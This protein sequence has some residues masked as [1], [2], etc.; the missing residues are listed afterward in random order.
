MLIK[1]ISFSCIFAIITMAQLSAYFEPSQLET[2]VNFPN[3]VETYF[4]TKNNGNW[5]SSTTWEVSSDQINW[6]AS[7]SYP[8]ENATAVE[9][10]APHEVTLDQHNLF[11]QNTSVYGTLVVED[12]DFVVPE[13]VN[14][15]ALQVKPSGK[16]L[17]NGQGVNNG[18]GKALVETNGKVEL[19]KFETVSILAEKFISTH[20]NSLFVF[21]DLAIV[22]WNYNDNE[23]LGSVGFS[24]FFKMSEPHTFVV[25]QLNQDFPKNGESFGGGTNHVFNAVLEVEGSRYLRLQGNGN[26][27]FVGGIQGTGTLKVNYL[28]GHGKLI[29]GN[30]HI[31]PTL[32]NQGLL[33]IEV[34]HNLL[35]F[36]NGGMVPN[37]AEVVL[38][39]LNEN[40]EI[41]RKNGVFTIDGTLDLG[42]FRWTNSETLG[43][44]AVNGILRTAH[45][46]GLHGGSSAIPSGNLTLND[47]SRIV[48]NGADQIISNLD[49]YHLVCAGSGVKT[50]QNATKIHS[51]GSVHIS[52]DAVVDFTLHNLASTGANNTA[53]SMDGGRLIL[54]RGGTQPNMRGNYDLSAG[55]VEF[56][57]RNQSIRSSQ[58][59]KYQNIEV[60]GEGVRNSSGH[61]RLRSNGTFV[62]KENSVFTIKKNSIRC[63]DGTSSGES[64]EENCQVVVSSNAVFQTG[65]SQGFS[66]F[67]PTFSDDAAIAFEISDIQ[68]MNGSTVEYLGEKAQVIS[69]QTN[70]G[71]GS[72]GNYYNLKISG[73]EILPFEGILTVNHLTQISPEG[74][75]VL[76]EVDEYSPNIHALYALKGIQVEEGGSLLLKNNAVLMQDEDAINSGAIQSEKTFHFSTERKQYNFVHSPLVGQ[77]LKEIYPNSSHVLRYN[78]ATDF[79][80]TTDGSYLPGRGLAM[81]EASGNG[82]EEVSAVFEGLPM[83]G[84]FSYPLEKAGQGFNLVGNPYPS[85]LDIRQLY[86]DNS[87]WIHNDFYFWDNRTNEIY[88]QQG[89]AYS[90]VNYA[91][92][93]ATAGTNGTGLG[94]ACTQ[95]DASKIPTKNVKIG[96]AFILQAKSAGALNFKN[97]YRTVQNDGPNFL[98]KKTD[99]FEAVED[100]RFWLTMTTPKGVTVM[101]AIVYFDDGKDAFSNDDTEAFQV[102]DELYSWVSEHQMI[103]QGK[104]AF[105]VKDKV[106]LGF[107]AFEEGIYAIKLFQQ[108]GIFNQ[109]Q[110]IYLMDEYLG[111]IH[112]LS[113]S[114]YVFKTESGEFNDRFVLV[115]ELDESLS[116]L[117]AA[118]EKLQIYQQNESL[119]IRSLKEDLRAVKAFD[120]SGQLLFENDSLT[121]KNYVL[122]KGKLAK[123]SLFLLLTTADET[124]HSF[125]IYHP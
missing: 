60:S 38:T 106:A 82:T 96:T 80:V 15:Y 98:G 65:N 9:I 8:D 72:E 20:A 33:S 44:I 77:N 63:Y 62:L 110:S 120:L 74:R 7:F 111:E 6:T 118:T 104:S 36:S 51:E 107:R 11:L 54:G 109:G 19:K 30:E 48:Y 102:S 27:T 108:E 17:L 75:L 99:D 70:V 29:I 16:F 14:A 121:G 73:D 92:F 78:E 100:D 13:K 43:G 59:Q 94:A 97:S 39:S 117:N 124:I 64:I 88:E 89:A 67:T 49:Y 25:F 105:V 52:E 122:P 21:E 28:S 90:G 10:L 55:V 123:K 116:S 18:N 4:R 115:Y 41:T 84:N 85:S 58:S 40:P 76:A 26:K 101:N 125:K 56:V 3:E 87:T 79:F 23:I 47:D 32:G 53:F 93:N 35:Q 83:N 66:G 103:I 119:H 34:P 2:V 86:L 113:E 46:G 57:G 114:P 112:H 1:L 68:L 42:K 71:Q 91:T 81:K 5:T 50:P 45:S 22:N 12:N 24:E 69:T 95:C 61:I 37:A 31:T